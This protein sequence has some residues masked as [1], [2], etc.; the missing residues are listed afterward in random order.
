MGVL[1]ITYFSISESGVSQTSRRISEKLKKDKKLGEK[2]NLI[3]N[4]LN[5]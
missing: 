1:D 4:R 5:L 2:I 3:E